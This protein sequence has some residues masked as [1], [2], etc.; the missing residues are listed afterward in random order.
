MSKLVTLRKSGN[1]LIL[2]VPSDL[3]DRVG[4]KYKVENRSDGSIVYQPVE[5]Q[6]I[7]DNPDWM[8][9]DYQRDLLE[10]PE[11]RPLNPVGK[12]RLEE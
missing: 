12:E 3:K 5:K 9:Y 1:S 10:D 8:Q 7:F 4:S 11:L 2:T 6:N